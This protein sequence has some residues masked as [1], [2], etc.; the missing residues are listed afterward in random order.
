[1]Y[2]FCYKVLSPQR[3]IPNRLSVFSVFNCQY[4]V[5]FGIVNT[6][7]GVGIG[8]SKYR[9]GISVYRPKTTASITL[10]SNMA[11]YIGLYYDSAKHLEEM[12]SEFSRVDVILM[13]TDPLH[14]DW[15]EC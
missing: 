13:T 15:L 1:M 7:V 5:F 14:N 2:T 6:D 9:F 4:S 11:H 3:Q 8:I 12:L 10:L